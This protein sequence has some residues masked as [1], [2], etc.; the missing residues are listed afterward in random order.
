MSRA[1]VFK[2][3]RE[4]TALQNLGID[5]TR[6]FVNF[7]GDTRPKD[8]GPFIVI[9]WEESTLFNQTYTGMSN[10]LSRAPRTVTFWA[11]FPEETSTDFTDIDAILNA[12]DEAIAPLEHYPGDDGVTITCTRRS[13]R[14][15]DMR[16]PS[17]KTI[18]RNATYVILSRATTG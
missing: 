4:S 3:L 18:C 17:Y 1:A 8:K 16:D 9:R 7:Q 13:G 2:A 12:V 14:S 11:H 6:I 15:S 10:G 5:A